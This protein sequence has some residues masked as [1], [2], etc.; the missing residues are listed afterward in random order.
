MSE[1]SDLMASNDP[2]ATSVMSIGPS[3][4]VNTTPPSRGEAPAQIHEGQVQA[5][6]SAPPSRR[7]GGAGGAGGQG[8]PRR[9]MQKLNAEQREAFVATCCAFIVL[10]PNIQQMLLQQ[11][12]V[13]GTNSTLLTLVNASLVGI[14][15]FVLREHIL[16]VL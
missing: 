9:K 14:L 2:M 5:Y 4:P 7:A 16:D 11:V 13:L 8:T 15:F 3:P 1:I 10:L 6:T 12:P